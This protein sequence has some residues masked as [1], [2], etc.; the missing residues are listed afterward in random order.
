MLS[1]SVIVIIQSPFPLLVAKISG[2]V[3]NNPCHY[4]GPIMTNPKYQY[5]ASGKFVIII[6]N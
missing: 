3:H 1:P 5:M 6:Q 4:V 2:L